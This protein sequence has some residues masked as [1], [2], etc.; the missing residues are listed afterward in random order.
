MY[1]EY[2]I[3]E[4]AAK[5]LNVFGYTEIKPE[6]ILVLDYTIGARGID[7]ILVWDWHKEYEL[8]LE[9]SENNMSWEL[10]IK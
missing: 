4:F 6:C 8:I 7:Y 1:I 10:E 3:K 5:V 9:A 2:Q